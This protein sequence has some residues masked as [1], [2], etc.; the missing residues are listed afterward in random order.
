[1]AGFCQIMRDEESLQTRGHM[2]DYLIALLHDS[3]DF[4]GKQQK[5]VMQYS[6]VELSKV[7]L[8]AGLKQKKSTGSKEQMCRDIH[9]D[10]LAILAAK[11]FIKQVRLIRKVPNQCHEYISM[12]TLV[13]LPNKM[14]QKGCFIGIFA[15]LVLHRMARSVLIVPVIAK[16]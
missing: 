12:R 2:L 11:K 13:L 7:K 15:V 6:Y 5:L 14:K 1:M 10:P 16:N 8:L 9:L 4:C 3:N